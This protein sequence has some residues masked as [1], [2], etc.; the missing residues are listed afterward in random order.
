M[1]LLLQGA[2]GEKYVRYLAETRALHTRKAAAHGLEFETRIR[3]DALPNRHPMWHKLAW[4]IAALDRH[5]LVIW[6]D[7]DA[8]WTGR[9]NIADALPADADF[10]GVRNRAGSLNA[11]CMWVRRSARAFL[12]RCFFAGPL[13]RF[14]PGDDQARI[15]FELRFA[16]IRAVEL[17]SRWNDYPYRRDMPTPPV[18]VVAFHGLCGN[19]RTSIQ[20]AVRRAEQTE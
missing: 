12:S 10:G 6:L 19:H 1:A 8:V 15:N 4:V 2:C 9:E 16:D 7:S 14:F 17:D 13:S 11:G 20:C 5:D 3:T 18:Q